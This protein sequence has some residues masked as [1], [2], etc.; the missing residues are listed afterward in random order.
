MLHV[1]Q[2]PSYLSLSLILLLL[3]GLQS[4]AY[5]NTFYNAEEYF[6]AAQK[7]T[8]DNQ[9][10][11]V[12]TQ[13]INLYSKAIEKSKKLLQRYP[14][15][16]YR[17]DAQFLIAKSYYFKGDYALARK[18]F[19]ELALQY[20]SSPHTREVPLWIGRC[21]VK[22][23]DLEM[24]RH[25]AA[26]I[27]K[28]KV[29]RGLEADALLLMGEIAVKQDSLELAEQYLERVIDRSPD[30]FTKAQAQFQVGKMRESLQDYGG[31][32]EAYR[33]VAKYRP[34]ESL[35][36]EAIIR[37][38]SML[39][40]LD[41]DEDAVALIKE[42]LLSDKFVDIRGQ[43]EVELAKLYRVMGQVDEAEAK[44]KSIIEEYS[45]QEEAA[46]ADYFLGEL[47]LTQKLDYAAAQ[48]AFND[49]KIQSVR[50][51][52]VA[53]G[54]EHIKQLEHYEKLQLD[55]ANLERQLAG[56]PPVVKEKKSA[57]GRNS[58]RSRGRSR[59]GR[60]GNPAT[61]PKQQHK[62]REVKS[63]TIVQ[64]SA[65]DSLRF[66]A[67]MDE[68]RYALAEYM[69]FEFARVDTTLELLSTLEIASQDSSIKRQAAYMQY[70]ALESVK[71]AAGA[72]RQAMDHIQDS[73]PEF[74]DTIMHRDAAAD[75]E[76]DPA[77]QRFEAILPLF[78]QG[79]W[80]AAA[81]AYHLL[82]EDSTVSTPIRVK[83]TFNYAWLNDNFLYQR[84]AALAAYQFLLEN[85]PNDPLADTARNRLRLIQVKNTAESNVANE[86][87]DQNLIADPQSVELPPIQAPKGPKPGDK[88]RDK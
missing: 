17:D 59:S 2:R 88:E 20:G 67:S 54:A 60:P 71:G 72:A 23:G 56:R 27:T 9:S 61:N 45:H 15:S 65:E 35:K 53:K 50:S 3:G 5:Y 82:Q 30:G 66:L 63:M 81:E 39:K 58:R 46:E 4:C 76:I 12:S 19:E 36:V 16:K 52:Y 33:T 84:D 8:R 1:F 85:F 51:P 64:V 38:T 75:T 21:L 74:Y 37:Q 28:T 42:M 77:E 34:S 86:A 55:Y 62:E 83:A 13:E 47:Y 7:L 48:K 22:T 14:D 43:L 25:E 26:R 68:N 69:L 18:Y 87:A 73:Y 70:Y 11:A 80:A 24:A 41:R 78:D 32:L 6:A 49:A 10:E 57:Q 40:A 44:L 31:A 79:Q 29:D